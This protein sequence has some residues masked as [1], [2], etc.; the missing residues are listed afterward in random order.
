MSRVFL[1]QNG[2][3]GGADFLALFGVQSDNAALVKTALASKVTRQGL[4][5]AFGAA[6]RMKR[7]A[8]IPILKAAL[9]ALPAEPAA[10]AFVVDPATLGRYAGTYRAGTAGMTMTVSCPGGVAHRT[11][12]RPTGVSSHPIGGRGVSRA[13]GQCDAHVQRARRTG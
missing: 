2:W 3:E 7:A 1:L 13:G 8:L 12:A 9:D 11:G 4:Q 6:E 5:A 10:P